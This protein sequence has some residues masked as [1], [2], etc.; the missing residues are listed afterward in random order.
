MI[1]VQSSLPSLLTVGLNLT[2]LPQPVIEHFRIWP[3]VNEV[4]DAH[5]NAAKE[6]R[7]IQHYLDQDDLKEMISEPLRKLSDKD[8]TKIIKNT[9]NRDLLREWRAEEKRSKVLKAI[10]D[11]LDDIKPDVPQNLEENK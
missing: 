6:L 5:W 8:A 2:K 4:E 7:V 11:Q 1:R 10:D 9:V 3:G